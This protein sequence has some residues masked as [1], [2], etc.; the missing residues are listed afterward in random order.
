MAKGKGKPGKGMP[1]GK[2]GMAG[3]DNKNAMLPDALKK[4]AGGGKK[5]Y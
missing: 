4:A 3:K 2:K 1:K 5:G